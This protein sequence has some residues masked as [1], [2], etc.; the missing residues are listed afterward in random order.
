MREILVCVSAIKIKI[1]SCKNYFCG[2][3]LIE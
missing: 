3:D 1:I 2:K